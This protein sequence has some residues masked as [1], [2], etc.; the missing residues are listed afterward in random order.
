MLAICQQ[1]TYSHLSSDHFSSLS[2]AG[3]HGVLGS[4]LPCYCTPTL[5][6]GQGA[7]LQHR[8]VLLNLNQMA[9]LPCPSSGTV[10]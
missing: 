3:P 4:A 8:G 7:A 5:F 2:L 6:L 9:P 1:H 10:D